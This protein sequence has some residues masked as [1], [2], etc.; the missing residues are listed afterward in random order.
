MLYTSGAYIEKRIIELITKRNAVL[1]RKNRG[2]FDGGAIIQANKMGKREKTPVCNNIS[3]GLN[4]SWI[5]E[6]N[7]K[8]AYRR[9]EYET[10][11]QEA[12]GKNI[13]PTK[14][15]G[16]RENMKNAPV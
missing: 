1:I 7:K 3:S 13:N 8:P 5:W 6:I 11:N 15:I 16:K 4:T 14:P 10:A 2:P 9:I 12:K